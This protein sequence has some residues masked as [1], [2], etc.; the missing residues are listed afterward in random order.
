MNN[1]EAVGLLSRLLEWLHQA[2]L[3]NL[4][5]HIQLVYVAAGAQ[6]VDRIE[7]QNVASPLPQ[8]SGPRGRD[9]YKGERKLPDVLSTEKAMALWRKAQEAGFVD[10]DYYPFGTPFSSRL[11]AIK[12]G[13]Q[14]FKYNGKEFDMMHGL[15]TYDYGARQYYPLLA[16]W[17]RVDP[18]CEK[19]YNVSPYAYCHNNPI[20]RIDPD[21]MDDYYTRSGDYLGSNKAKTDNIYITD[22]GQYRQLEDGKYAINTSSRVAL[23][24]AELEA[25]AYSKIFTNCFKLG[26]GDCSKLADGIIQVTVWQTE[27]GTNI[28]CNHTENSGNEGG[29]LA[30]TALDHTNGAQIT[31]YVFPKGKVERELLST[32]SNIASTLKDHEFGGHYEKGFTHN[33]GI[34][35]PTYKMQ[36]ESPIWNKTTQ[37][38]KEYQKGVIKEHGY[39]W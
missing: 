13:Y 1:E 12:S 25:N 34:P 27:G 10:D 11:Y 38:F 39:D 30:S 14:P 31:A 9:S 24:D 19:Y 32:R 7:V 35:D 17:D 8:T 21:G 16:R 18:L 15:N 28:S 23:N 29:A 20:N 26:G 33:N 37:Q 2:D 4:G 5:S 6:H 22:E 36:M 3:K